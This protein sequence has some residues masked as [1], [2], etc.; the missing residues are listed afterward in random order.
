MSNAAGSDFYLQR[1]FADIDN[2][3]LS[4]HT[5]RNATPATDKNTTTTSGTTWPSDYFKFSV[6]SLI[7]ATRLYGSPG[8]LDLRL[9][10]LRSQFLLS[11]AARSLSSLLIETILTN[12]KR[13]STNSVSVSVWR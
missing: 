12:P 10:I 5:Y 9:S 7:R 13:N 8:F 6:V 1:V 11:L 3:V 2:S 4:S